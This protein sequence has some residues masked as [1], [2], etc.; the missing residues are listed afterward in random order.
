MA[1]GILSMSMVK[2]D[3]RK[4]LKHLYNPPVKKVVEVDVPAMNF[5]MVDG[6]GDPN[7]TLEYQQAVEGLYS[8]AY[9]LKFAGKKSGV[10]YPVMPL[11]GLWWM[12]SMGD[13]YGDL[14][15]TEAKS[16]WQWTMMIMQPD[17]ITLNMVEASTEVLR[18]KKN[19]PAL[20]K[21]RFE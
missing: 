17:A 7:T 18:R 2:L 20:D 14:D 3:L 1:K 10:D 5:L 8:L 19:P 4:E 13:K 6:R 15:F 9:A 21:V 12:E 16:R 11:E